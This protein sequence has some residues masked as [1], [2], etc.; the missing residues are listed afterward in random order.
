MRLETALLV[1]IGLV[2][3]SLTGLAFVTYLWGQAGFV[4]LSSPLPLIL[5]ATLGAIG[6]QTILGGFLL[7]IIGGNEAT[8]IPSEGSVR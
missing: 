6:L 8:F 3:A 1:G 2:L 5:S 4:A 7:A